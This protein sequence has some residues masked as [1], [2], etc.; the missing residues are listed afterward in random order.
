MFAVLARTLNYLPQ[1]S[2]QRLRSAIVSI[3][4]AGME[5]AVL[6]VATVFITGPLLLATRWVGGLV[7]ASANYGLNRLLVFNG[8]HQLDT[9]EALRFAATALVSVTVSSSLWWA[10]IQATGLD[11]RVLH[12]ICMM[13]VWVLLT[14]P[15]LRRWVFSGLEA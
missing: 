15:L 3:F 7:G 12:P 1:M 6:T 9:F 10:L 4:T 13:T 5:I 2:S 8:R 14:F 11:P